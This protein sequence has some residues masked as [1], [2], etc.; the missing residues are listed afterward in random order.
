MFVLQEVGYLDLL[1]FLNGICFQTGY[2]TPY[3]L[4]VFYI[5]IYFQNPPLSLSDELFNQGNL[6]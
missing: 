2:I 1:D 4:L 3:N 5:P 6:T